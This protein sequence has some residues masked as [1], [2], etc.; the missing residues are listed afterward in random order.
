VRAVGELALSVS[1][2]AQGIL[3]VGASDDQQHRLL[4]ADARFDHKGCGLLG[5]VEQAAAAKRE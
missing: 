2:V 1:D 3:G 4:G 5:T